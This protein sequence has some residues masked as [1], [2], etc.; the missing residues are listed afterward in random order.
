MD[1]PAQD[2]SGNPITSYLRLLKRHKTTLPY[3]HLICVSASPNIS[4][5]AALLRLA[6]A[7]GP[8][9]AVLQVH[10]DIIDDWSQE[11]ARRLSCVAKK[12]GFLI[13]EG[14]RILNVQKRSG[15]HQGPREKR[16]RF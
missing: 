13:W 16:L 5:M 10:A 14:G 7:V 6:R 1:P 8:Y 12:H 9:I 2:A 4:T 11:A 3:G 15:K